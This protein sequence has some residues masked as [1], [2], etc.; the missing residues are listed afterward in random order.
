MNDNSAGIFAGVFGMV[1][2]L[3]WLV[4]FIAVIAGM[5]KTFEKAGKPG[6]GALIPI[7]NMILFAEIA[8]KPAWWGILVFVPCVGIIF[9]VLLCIEV[10]K[11]F[12]QGPLFGVA[13]AFFGFICFPILGFG[14]AKYQPV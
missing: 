8:R 7:Y 5:W 13:L 12:G 2:M 1:M 4:L 9:L 10:A 11:N 14:S 6:W 3:V